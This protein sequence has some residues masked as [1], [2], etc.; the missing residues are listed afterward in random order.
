MEKKYKT[1]TKIKKGKEVKK[2]RKR[3]KIQTTQC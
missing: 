1:Q 2:K 3:N